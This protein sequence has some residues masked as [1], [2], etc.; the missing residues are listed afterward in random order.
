MRSFLVGSVYG[1]NEVSTRNVFSLSTRWFLKGLQHQCNQTRRVFLL[2]FVESRLCG[3]SSELELSIIKTRTGE[4]G[5]GFVKRRER[6]R[7]TREA[8]M[9]PRFPVTIIDRLT[10]TLGSCPL[11]T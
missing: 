2:L 6:E 4:K 11:S 8:T 7:E 3:L 9:S 10:L 1:G 5:G